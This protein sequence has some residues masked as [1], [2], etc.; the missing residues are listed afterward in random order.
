M[1]ISSLPLFDECV[2]IHIAKLAN[3]FVS[4]F[5]MPLHTLL[6]YFQY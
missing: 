5:T 3:A 2:T 1:V 4:I 6:N